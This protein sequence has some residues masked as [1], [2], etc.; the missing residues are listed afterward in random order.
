MALDRD[1]IQAKIHYL[2]SELENIKNHFLEAELYHYLLEQLDVQ[3]RMLKE[4]EVK[5]RFAAI[6]SEQ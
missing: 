6:D 3:R 4:I 2:E 1:K 5:E